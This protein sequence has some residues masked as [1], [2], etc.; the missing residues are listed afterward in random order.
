MTKNTSSPSQRRRKAQKKG[1]S[2]IRQ[3]LLMGREKR[4]PEAKLAFVAALRERGTV[5]YAAQVAGISNETYYLWVGADEVFKEQVRGA[6]TDYRESLEEEVHRRAVVGVEKPVIYQGRLMTQADPKDKRKRVPLTIN[7]KSD[8]LLMFKTK[9]E[10]P[11]K[12]RENDGINIHT[13][14]LSLNASEDHLKILA[15]LESK[16]SRLA[17]A[18]GPQQIPGQPEPEAS[19]VAGTPLALLGTTEPTPSP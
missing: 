2:P 16:F 12:Y 19:A 9:A 5:R 3:S 18:V 4:R 14:D 8:L 10:M 11:G 7:E 1:K 13:R 15:D 6:I 17:R